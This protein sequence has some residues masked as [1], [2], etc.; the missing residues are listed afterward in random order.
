MTDS[1]V[2]LVAPGATLVAASLA[3][4]VALSA[5][6]SVQARRHEEATRLIQARRDRDQDAARRRREQVYEDLL[7]HMTRQFTGEN[8]SSADAPLRARISTWGN[9][10]VIAAVGQ[11][12]AAALE[13]ATR[14]DGVLQPADKARIMRLYYAVYAAAQADLNRDAP[15]QDV[16]LGMV[17]DDYAS[18]QG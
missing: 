6:Q 4:L 7:A 13:I 18:G 11:F 17:F 16:V 10:E 3:G 2:N 5:T 14:S 9:G 15:P 1:H 12:N 8:L